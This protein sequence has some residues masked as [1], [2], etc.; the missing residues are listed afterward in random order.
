MD[1]SHFTK[2]YRICNADI[3]RCVSNQNIML[4]TIHQY[5]TENLKPSR[6]AH[7]MNVA[8]LARSLCEK[9]GIDGEKGYLAGLLHDC[10]KQKSTPEQLTLIE[11]YNIILEYPVENMEPCLHADTG[12][13]VARD[14]FGID[15]EIYNA[16][17]YH[18]LGRENMTD[19]EKIIYIADKCEVGRDTQLKKAPLWRE[20]AGESLDKALLDI[21]SDNILYLASKGATPHANTL[22][23]LSQLERSTQK[24]V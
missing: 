8:D 20:M 16:I 15:D 9:H 1:I 7:T 14:I 11:K 23:I 22:A 4:N 17:K 10:T 5:L 21:I 13:E 6:L 24:E 19:L 3:S 12:A 18:T 2:I